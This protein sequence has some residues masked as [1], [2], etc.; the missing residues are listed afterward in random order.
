MNQLL[1]AALDYAERGWPV[2]PLTYPKD[3][4]CSCGQDVG[5]CKP[6]KH[7]DGL[8]VPH[9]LKD[10]TVDVDQIREW[11]A[12][13]RDANVGIRTGVGFDVLD[14]DGDEGWRSLAQTTSKYGCLASS[15]VSLTGGGGAHYL[16]LPTGIG[17]RAGFRDHL[18]WR[19]AGGYIVAPPSV[20][21]SGVRY[22]WAWPLDE[23][24]LEPAP[25]WLVDLVG[26]KDER[27]ARPASVGQWAAARPGGGSAYGQ[28]AL[29]NTVDRLAAATEGTR[30]ASL[31][32]AAIGLGHLVAGGELPKEDVIAALFATAVSIGLSEVETEKTI[33]S[34]LTAGMAEPRTAPKRGAA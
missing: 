20:H 19:G 5:D 6:A 9:G 23:V 15:P 34:G 1:E 32:N 17:N 7:P 14:V 11:W 25:T 16:F 12:R 22:E 21:I 24:P 18:D 30:N 27:P 4:G 33:I 28:A 3:G 31:N 13:S 8:L 29:R 26:R 10:A 2:L